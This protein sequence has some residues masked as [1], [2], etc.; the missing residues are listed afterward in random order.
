MYFTYFALYSRK[1]DK[2]EWSKRYW[3]CVKFNPGTGYVSFV[4]MYKDNGRWI[5]FGRNVS[6]KVDNNW[7]WDDTK[8]MN[9]YEVVRITETVIRADNV[10][11]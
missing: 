3:K 4:Q 7:D 9:G 5:E 1:T 11:R 8:R 10:V 6:R 2:V